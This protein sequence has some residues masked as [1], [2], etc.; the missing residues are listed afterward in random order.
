[1]I[2]EPV[3]RRETD[4]TAEPY[5]SERSAPDGPAGVMTAGGG[6]SGVRSA[7]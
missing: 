3:H 2:R 1:L 7:K 4:W 5:R 6:A